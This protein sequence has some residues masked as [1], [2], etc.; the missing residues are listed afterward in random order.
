VALTLITPEEIKALQEIEKLIQQVITATVLP[1]YEHDPTFVAPEQAQA[2][3]GDGPK[4]PMKK[5]NLKAK[6]RAKALGKA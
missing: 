1:G 2:R 5:G 3:H 6:L 4:K